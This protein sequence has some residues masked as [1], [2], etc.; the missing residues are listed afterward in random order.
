MLGVGKK[1]L[2]ALSAP[3]KALQQADS[4]ITGDAEVE[5]RAAQRT[6]LHVGVM[7]A[8]RGILR[9]EGRPAH[10]SIQRPGVTTSSFVGLPCRI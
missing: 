2:K 7:C 3:P 10:T 4:A 9:G 8:I 5:V 6:S 1:T